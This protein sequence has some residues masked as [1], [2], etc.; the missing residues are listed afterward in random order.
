MSSVVSKSESVAIPDSG[1]DS[2]PIQNLYYLLCYAWRHLR[3]GRPIPMPSG[4]C[5]NLTNLFALILARG[6]R[7]EVRKGIHREYVEITD[8]TPKI[9]GRLGIRESIMRQTWSHGRMV[10]HFDELS[11]NVLPNQIIRATGERLIRSP[12]LTKENRSSLRE[13][14]KWLFHVEPIRVSGQHFSRVQVQRRNRTYRF[15]LN[16]CELLH[17]MQLP[18]EQPKSS[19]DTHDPLMRSIL[20]DE[21]TM[22]ALFEE[23]VRNFYA[24]HL[25]DCRV[26]DFWIQWDRISWDEKSEQMLPGLHSDVTI[27]GPELRV[28]LDC[29]YYQ[30]ALSGGQRDDKVIG[31]HLFQMLAYLQN[32]QRTFSNWSDVCDG[33]IKPTGILLYPAVRRP[34][35]FRYELCGFPVRVSSIDL[36]RPWQEIESQMIEMINMN[37]VI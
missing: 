30:N 34:F 21:M 8:N 5:R 37:R 22:H 17:R 26:K 4:D 1:S 33:G 9:R 20:R 28:I 13:Q 2:I 23:F 19:A 27:D 32:A 7:N 24:E 16:V 11:H 18:G 29:K 36:D 3:Q 35:D 31:G 25:S 15:L 6:I 12:E 14:M 10:C